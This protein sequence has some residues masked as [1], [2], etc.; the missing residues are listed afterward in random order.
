M[1]GRKERREGE[2]TTILSVL[3]VG[4]EL[5]REEGC[6]AFAPHSATLVLYINGGLSYL[7][8][9]FTQ[10]GEYPTTCL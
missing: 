7:V 4:E 3:S 5:G 8:L 6:F 2:G 10:R 9:F 1:G